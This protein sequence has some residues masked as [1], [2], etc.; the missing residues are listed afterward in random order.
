MDDGVA[1][2]VLCLLADS[3]P[4]QFS[5]LHM[6]CHRRNDVIVAMNSRFKLHKVHRLP[7]NRECRK[8]FKKCLMAKQCSRHSLAS[9]HF[10]SADKKF[11]PQNCAR[12]GESIDIVAKF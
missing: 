1:D 4:A 7:Q 5:L 11:S 3:L 2:V 9:G 6:I 10:Q 12:G 8:L